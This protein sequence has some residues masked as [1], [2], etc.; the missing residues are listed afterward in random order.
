MRRIKQ[1]DDVLANKIAAGEVIERCAN[2]VKELVENSIDANSTKIDIIIEEGGL[3]LIKIIDNGYG[4]NREDALLC[5]SRHATSK[6][7]N[8]QDLFCIQTLGFRG[9]AIPSIASISDFELKTSDGNTGS[10][11]V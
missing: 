7:T 5:F 10:K 9:E 4:M 2:V 11:V 8:D 1:L 3:N 6:I